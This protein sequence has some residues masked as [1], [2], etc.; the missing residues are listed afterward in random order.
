M[1]GK[2]KVAIYLPASGL[3]PDKKTGFLNQT[4]IDRLESVLKNDDRIEFV[5]NVDFK[6]RVSVVN[7]QVLCDDHDLSKA[8]L[9]FWYAPGLFPQLDILRA[10][11]KATSVLKDPES[12]I[13]VADKFL[14]HSI[15]KA[16]G[17]P[18]ADF[19]L[20]RFDDHALMKK[21]IDQWKT[22][23][24]KPRL[25]S[26]GRGII[27]ATD[28]ETLRDVAGMLVVEHQQKWIMV[29]RFYENDIDEWISTTLIGGKVV[30]GYRKKISKF[31]DWKVYDIEKRGGDAYY[32]DPSPVREMAEKAAALLDQ[33]IV[34]FD[35]I[36]TKEGY[37][38]VDENNFPGFYPE[39]FQAAKADPAFLIADMIIGSLPR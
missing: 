22:V 10:L 38:L 15:L 18:V 25:G 4:E 35:F 5:G 8:D 27:R 6:G 23:L 12:L 9:F 33:S 32:V 26:F 34:G 16:N 11:S 24:I 3:S 28:F 19:A 29:E 39:A 31:A 21:L 2:K 30:Y 1:K 36:K 7:N 37:I 17:L 20:I 14:S 13:T